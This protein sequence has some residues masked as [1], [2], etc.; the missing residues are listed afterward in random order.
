LQPNLQPMQPILKVSQRKDKK[1]DG[2]SPIIIQV[3]YKGKRTQFFTGVYVKET[4]F[5]DG[6]VINVA[7]KAYFNQLIL[8]K[9]NE[10]ER[11]YL[12][13]SM[14]TEDIVLKEKEKIN[15]KNFFTVANEMYEGLRI[16]T[17]PGY[18]DR[19]INAIKDFKDFAG[20]QT[21][22]S[23]TNELLKNYETHLLKEKLA[24][25]TI[26]RKFK[27]IKQVFISEGE[28][29]TYKPLTYKQPA[30]DFLTIEEIK[31]IE[32]VNFEH[33]VKYYFLLS[34]YTGLRYS[35]LS[36]VKERIVINNGVKK[37]ILSTTKTGSQV[38]IKLSD[39]LIDLIEKIDQ[40]LV[41]NVHA[42]RVLKDIVSFTEI[43]RKVT[44]HMARH[45]FAV[46]SASLG[47]PIEVVSR[48]LGH[49]SI[50]TTSIYYKITDVNLDNWMEKWN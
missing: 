21:F 30:R 34:C 45:S 19:C 27:R 47:M 37:I 22:Q 3:Y 36:K 6:K 5:K 39:K 43:K 25:N 14:Q 29:W 33:P 23:I 18:A 15:R 35:D 38:S 12:V 31:Q 46:N 24:R 7:N 1:Q 17:K 11:N 2:K 44:F 9:K 40:P 13:Q 32:G 28:K 8:N 4:D 26:N 50:R 48:L 16:R 20:E 10:I 42:N 41:S 49:S